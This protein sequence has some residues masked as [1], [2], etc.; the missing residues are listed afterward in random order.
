MIKV[1]EA[2]TA[3]KKTATKREAEKKELADVIE[4]EKLIEIK[5]EFFEASLTDEAKH[6]SGRHPYTL[7]QVYPRPAPEG[8]KTDGNL[9]IHLN[10]IRFRPDGPANKIGLFH[11]ARPS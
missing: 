1:F 10:G 4:Q 5:G 8:K 2:I 6:T 7:K 3:L 11:I 9:E